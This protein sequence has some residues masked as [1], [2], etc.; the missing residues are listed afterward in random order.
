MTTV[1]ET[2]N[3]IHSFSNLG[4]CYSTPKHA[5]KRLPSFVWMHIFSYFE[6]D[7]FTIYEKWRLFVSCKDLYSAFKPT[8]RPFF[9]VKNQR[10]LDNV[11]SYYIKNSEFLIKATATLISVPYLFLEEGVYSINN[12]IQHMDVMI[13]GKGV[14]KTI[15][16]GI[17]SS[18]SKLY[19]SDLTISKSEYGMIVKSDKFVNKYYTRLHNCD[20]CN[21]N[22]ILSVVQS[23]ILITN[24]NIYDNKIS[25]DLIDSKV[26]I[27]NS[28][29]YHSGKKITIHKNR[30]KYFTNNEYH[31]KNKTVNFDN[32][33]IYHEESPL[34][35]IEHI[36]EVWEYDDE[37]GDFDC[38]VRPHVVIS[39]TK[40]WQLWLNPTLSL[41][42]RLSFYLDR[43]YLYDAD[44]DYYDD[45]I[46]EGIDLISN[47]NYKTNFIAT[48][49]ISKE[50]FCKTIDNLLKTIDSKSNDKFLFFNQFSRDMISLIQV[51]AVTNGIPNIPSAF[52]EDDISI[53][54]RWY[55]GDILEEQIKDADAEILLFMKTLFV[56][57]GFNVVGTKIRT[58][59]TLSKVDVDMMNL[60]IHRKEGYDYVSYHNKNISNY[61]SHESDNSF[62]YDSKSKGRKKRAKMSKFGN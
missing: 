3:V 31:L 9:H 28:T 48:T 29:Y 13:Y 59:L 55:S 37:D 25:F 40:I 8:T 44:I 2:S 53:I 10:D 60:K 22:V 35:A 12:E 36:K 1:T 47:D 11:I 4:K 57:H 50:I 16:K 33:Q 42:N 17:K 39:N 6:K 62:D 51:Y 14:G 20:I 24:C 23:N 26:Q 43:E 46:I 19:L 18:N 56:S 5:E 32:C 38:Y 7:E 54:E 21:C 58:A 49:E 27:N 45:E 30:D 41:K 15:I 34:T 61:L 52:L